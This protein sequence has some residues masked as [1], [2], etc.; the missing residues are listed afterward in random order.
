MDP[1]LILFL[2]LE[3]CMFG[4]FISLF[5]FLRKCVEKQKID[6]FKKLSRRLGFSYCES[7]TINLQNKIALLG[8]DFAKSPVS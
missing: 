7:D 8:S 3:I 6:L 1:N 2:I 4:G 5:L